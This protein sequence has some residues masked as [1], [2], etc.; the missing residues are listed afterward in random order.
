[1]LLHVHRVLKALHR[2]LKALQ[3]FFW[4]IVLQ[5][6]VNQGHSLK[7]VLEGPPVIVPSKID[8]L[9]DCALCLGY[10]GECGHKS[11]FLRGPGAKSQN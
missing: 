5:F 11:T 6:I 2:V 8:I 4:P 7:S 3:Q 10:F 9:M 1:V